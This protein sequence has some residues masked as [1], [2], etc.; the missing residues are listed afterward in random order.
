MGK[1]LGKTLVDYHFNVNLRAGAEL[2]SDRSD[3]FSADGEEAAMM[4][5]SYV[6]GLQSENVAAVLAHFPGEGAAENGV[7]DK[8]EEELRQSDLLPFTAGIESRGRYH[9][10]LRHDSHGARTP[11][12]CSPLVRR[13]QRTCCE[14]AWALPA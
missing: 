13:G 11:P 12:R 6:T 10:S 9:S 4:V 3:C 1:D 14:I 7:C 2:S 8:A 5:S